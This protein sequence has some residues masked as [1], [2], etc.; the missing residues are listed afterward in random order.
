MT[1]K[2]LAIIVGVIV[3]V[4]LAVRAAPRIA[5][6]LAPSDPDN[7]GA[8]PVLALREIG[9]RYTSNQTSQPLALYGDGFVQGMKVKV[10][11]LEL[12]PFV[13]DG[14][15]AYARLPPIALP[16]EVSERFFAVT[17]EGGLGEAK[18]RV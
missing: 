15:H 3:V 9:P 10:G 16:A 12:T 4:A 1:V 18:L 7:G 14:R 5:R 6:M 17:L 13:L 2:K 11:E 8:R